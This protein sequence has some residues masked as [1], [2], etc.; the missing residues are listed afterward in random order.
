MIRQAEAD[1]TCSN[2]QRQ[3]HI[4]TWAV[5]TG[6]KDSNAD[7]VAIAI[8]QLEVVLDAD[9]A[10]CARHVDEVRQWRSATAP[11]KYADSNEIYRDHIGPLM[12]RA[13][14]CGAIS[15]HSES[16]YLLCTVAAST[17]PEVD[18]VQAVREIVR[19]ERRIAAALREAL[20]SWNDATPPGLTASA[21]V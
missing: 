8:R 9:L 14:C 21:P 2:L 11:G 13:N 10:I 4:L 15:A 12:A 18:C 7:A 20:L 17:F 5:T 1:A 16:L 3:L 6:L 19:F